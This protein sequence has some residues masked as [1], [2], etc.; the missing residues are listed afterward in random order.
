[1]MCKN[2]GNLENG[3]VSVQKRSFEAQRVLEEQVI[4]YLHSGNQCLCNNHI[5]V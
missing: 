2:E 1:M 5:E 3:A 4:D